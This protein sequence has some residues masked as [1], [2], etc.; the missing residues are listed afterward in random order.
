MNLAAELYGLASKLPQAEYDIDDDGYVTSKNPIV[1]PF[2]EVVFGTLAS[3]IIFVLLYWK[4][5]PLIKKA[6]ADRTARIQGE[7]DRAHTAKA[8]AAVE[9]ERIRTALGDIEAERQRLLADAEVQADALLADGRTRLEAEI[10][11]LEARADADLVV[12]AGRTG[13]ELRSEIAR[14][15]AAAADRVVAESLDEATQQELIENF[16]ARVGTGATS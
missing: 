16:I 10:S 9:A 2:W 4:A 15:A 6:M 14:Y 7:I 1:P 3:G 8:D 5:W 13:D 12:A 11:E